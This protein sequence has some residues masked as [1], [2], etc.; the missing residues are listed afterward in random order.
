[1]G[2]VGFT[3]IQKLIFDKFAKNEDLRRHFYFTGGTALSVFHFGHRYSDDLDFFSEEEQNDEIINEFMGKIAQDLG[4]TYRFTRIE[5]TRMFEF[6]KEKK[7]L[8]K[9]DFGHFPY[10]RLEKGLWQN[11]VS[12]DGL[13]DIGANKI[14]TIAQRNDIKDFVDLYFLLKKFTLW[15]LIYAVE[16]KFQRETDILL[17]GSDFLKSQD[18]EFLPRMIKPIKLEELKIF[19]R[20][21]AMNIGK[22]AVK[23]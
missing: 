7:L 4:L 16:K 8:A 3:P 19:F 10:Q 9:V 1:M 18:F 12:I 6:V 17:L 23:P 21:Q 13:L 11:G 14:I 22:R 20:E 2:K 5:T 15:D